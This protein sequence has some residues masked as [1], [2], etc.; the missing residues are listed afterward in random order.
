MENEDEN[1]FELLESNLLEMMQTAVANAYRD[2]LSSE[3]SV[4]VSE[5]GVINE[6][7]PDGTLK[8]VKKISPPIKVEKEKIIKI[9]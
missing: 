1:S 7:F 8:F 4:L 5:N 3:G 2:A 9:K 6:V